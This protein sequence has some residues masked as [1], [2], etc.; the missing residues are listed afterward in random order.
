[1]QPCQIDTQALLNTSNNGELTIFKGSLDC[2]GTALAVKKYFLVPLQCSFLPPVL[3]IRQPRTTCLLCWER[4]SAGKDGDYVLWALSFPH[5]T[6]VGDVPSLF[7]S[8]SH[9]QAASLGPGLSPGW[10]LE[11]EATFQVICDQL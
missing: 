4:L 8:L 7:W 1:M 11:W 5:L 10:G 6:L 3:H 2:Y 9:G